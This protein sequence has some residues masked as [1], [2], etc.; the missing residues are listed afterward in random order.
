MV[1]AAMGF[2]A[3]TTEAT[4]S[5]AANYAQVLQQATH[6]PPPEEAHEEG[7]EKHFRAIFISDIHLGTPGCQ[8]EA[9]LEFLRTHSSDTLYLVG[10][11]ID[12]WQ[13]R[14]RWYW[15]QAH[16]DVVQ[17]LLRRARKGCRVVFVPGNHDEFA[18]GFIG[19]SF[20]GI[21]VLK[22][23]VHTTAQGLKLWVIHGDHF[24]GVIQLAKWLAYLGDNLYELTLKLNRYLNHLRAKFGLPY[25]SLSAY[26]K[27]KVKKAVNFI[28]DF[29]VAVATQAAKHGFQGVVCGHI[30]HAEIREINGILYC[31]D[32]DW[33]ESLTAMVEHM[34]G[35]L[36]I[37]SFD[38]V[39]QIRL[40]SHKQAALVS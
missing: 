22:E 19:H 23:T 30:H 9:L 28:S 7:V 20:G 37:L 17:K 38:E 1:S 16:N 26:L 18:R 29:E 10:D 21:E 39:N 31:N 25:W 8:A 6:E 13:L 4:P 32:G 35:R 11:I 2:V 40:S 3:P 34:D 14:R 24:D 33:V 36:E 27:L 5:V 15:P 12:G